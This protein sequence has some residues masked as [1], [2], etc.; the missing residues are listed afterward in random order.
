MLFLYVLNNTVSSTQ[1]ASAF[2]P[3]KDFYYVYDDSTTLK[4]KKLQKD[5]DIFRV[6]LFGAFLYISEIVIC[7]FFIYI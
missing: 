4:C 3:Q 7:H 2:A 5:F 6:L 1:L